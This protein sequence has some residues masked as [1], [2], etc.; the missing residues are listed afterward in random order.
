MIRAIGRH[1]RNNVV[2]YLALFAALTGTAYAADKIGSNDIRKGAVKSKQIADGQVKSRD[3]QDQRGVRSIDVKDGS[4]RG[5]DI[6]ESS[7]GKVPRSIRADV[8][9]ALDGFDPSQVLARDRIL[10]GRA[11][12]DADGELLIDWQ[13]AGMEVRTRDVGA[14]DAITDIRILNTNPPGGSS[15]YVA[16]PG[17]NGGLLEPGA[18]TKVGAFLGADRILVE[19]KGDLGRMM[20]LTCFPNVLQGG[21]DGKVQCMAITAGQ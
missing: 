11:A 10:Y 20:R 14:G 18:D 2:A 16:N 15:F 7:L 3:I 12:A 8:A 5:A 1:L 21:D 6:D 19:N 4:L 9:S 13:E 17:S